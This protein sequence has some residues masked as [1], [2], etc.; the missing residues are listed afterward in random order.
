MRGACERPL[1]ARVTPRERFAR[2]TAHI[3]DRGDS[4]GEPDLELVLD[5]LRRP[6]PL[7]LHVRVGVDQPRQART[8][9]SRR[10]RPCSR[11]PAA[12]ARR[13]RAVATGS[14]ATTCVIVPPCDDD[15][16]RS[17]GGSPVAIDDGGVADDES[18][19]TRPADDR[20]LRGGRRPAKSARA[21]TAVNR[22]HQ[23]IIICVEG[24]RKS[25][26]VGGPVDRWTGW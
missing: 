8:C 7:V 10:S 25:E 17:L 9:R 4:T 1:G 2:V 19:R 21:R 13:L 18:R 11:P 15:V 16:E 23:V 24:D 12:D 26:T 14:R 20:G 6:A 22:A 5:R 3:A